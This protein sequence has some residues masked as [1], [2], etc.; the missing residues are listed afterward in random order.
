MESQCALIV[1]EGFGP[2]RP[3][4]FLEEIIHEVNVRRVLAKRQEKS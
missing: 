2:Q 1:A 4:Q 3:L